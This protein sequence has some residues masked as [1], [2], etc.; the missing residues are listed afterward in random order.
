[1]LGA[2]TLGAAKTSAY[3]NTH[4]PHAIPF[5]ALELLSRGLLLL[6]APALVQKALTD[7]ERS[8]QHELHSRM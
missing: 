1:M 3:T 7:A 2:L 6:V 8:V 4:A 5:C